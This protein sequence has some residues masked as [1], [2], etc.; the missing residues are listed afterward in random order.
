MHKLF[1]LFS[2][3]RERSNKIKSLE[4]EIKNLQQQNYRLQEQKAQ[5]NCLPVPPLELITRVGGWADFDHFLGVGRKIFWDLK[6]LLKSVDK[7]FSSFSSILDFGCGCGR[8]TRFL[9]PANEQ[10][11]IGADIDPQSIAW[12]SQHLSHIAQFKVTNALP[13]LP[14]A[15]AEFDLVYCISVFTHLPEEMQFQWL[16]ELQR[17]LKPGGLLITSIHGETPQLGS[18]E[19]VAEF[20][21]KGFIYVHAGDTPGLPEF[22]QTTFHTKKYIMEQWSQYFEILN[23]QEWAI[24]NHQAGIICQKG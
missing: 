22:Y 4:T 3:L 23:V 17:V 12:C 24:N 14:F 16:H 18:P 2:Y 10:T 9:Q 6:R 11:I 13:P 7:E 5:C 20:D 19:L 8:I 21:R 15:D 1:N